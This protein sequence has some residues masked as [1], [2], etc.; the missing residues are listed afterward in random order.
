MKKMVMYVFMLKVSYGALPTLTAAHYGL[1]N[2]CAIIDHN[3]LQISGTTKEVCNTDPI[4]A[5][6][7]SFGWSVRHVDGHDFTALKE[8]FGSLPFT[9]GKPSLVIAHTVKGKG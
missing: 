9:E 8:V 3:K 4:D 1:D 2:L 5:K 7:E 6:F